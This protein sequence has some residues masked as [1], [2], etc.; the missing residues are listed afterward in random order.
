MGRREVQHEQAGVSRFADPR[1]S[2][3]AEAAQMGLA[4]A[5]RTA[6]VRL[7]PIALIAAVSLTQAS[8]FQAAGIAKRRAG[9]P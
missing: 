8:F 7:A 5:P 4:W 1:R 9:W 6:S 3:R 2:G